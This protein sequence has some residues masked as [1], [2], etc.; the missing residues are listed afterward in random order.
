[1]SSDAGDNGLGDVPMNVVTLPSAERGNHH[2]RVRP[3]LES[4]NRPGSPECDTF[5]PVTGAQPAL[6]ARLTR[7]TS[8]GHRPPVEPALAIDVRGSTP[9]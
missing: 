7:P 4:L 8:A 1:M 9:A 2:R 3:V 6:P 5:L